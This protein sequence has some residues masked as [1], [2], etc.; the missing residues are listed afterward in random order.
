MIYVGAADHFGLSLIDINRS[1]LDEEWRYARKNDFYTFVPS[2][3]D[4]WPL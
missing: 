4:V 1:N 3:L 2:D